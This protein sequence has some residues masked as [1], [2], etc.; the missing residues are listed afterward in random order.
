MLLAVDAGNTN[1]VFALF[2]TESDARPWG[3]IRTRWRIT[4]DPRRT[5]D[6]YAVWLSQLLALE[7]FARSDVTKVII[8]TV[9]PRALHNLQTLARKYFDTEPVIAGEGGWD[10]PLDVDEPQNVGADRALNMIAAKE[11]HPGDLI[12]IDFGT[13]TTFDLVD[14]RGAYK[15]GIIAPGI[16]LS[17]DALVSAA[18]K[19]PRM[20]ISEPDSDSVIGRNTVDQMHIGIYWGYIAMMEG[21]VARMRRQAGRPVKVIATGGLAILFEKHTDIF[22]AVEADLTLHGLAILWSRSHKEG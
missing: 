13:A 5:A 20:A 17:L 7:G 10:F 2:D 1:I 21:L 11:T 12:I 9:V 18:A 16:N 19:L 6:E 4:T 8:G 15:G 14:Y 22:D 3:E